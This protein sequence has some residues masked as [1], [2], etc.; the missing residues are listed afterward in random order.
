MA[1]PG[2]ITAVILLG[3][4]AD[5]HL[6]ALAALIVLIAA[7]TGACALVFAAAGP[8]S[9]LLGTTGTV[10]MSR[11]LGV[12]LAALAVQVVVDGVGALLG[13]S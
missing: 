3:A 12:V 5:G 8:I 13:R 10:V 9:R 11:L 6:P 4:R 7:V 2:A 1:G